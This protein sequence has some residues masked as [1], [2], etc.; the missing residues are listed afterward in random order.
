MDGG[1]VYPSAVLKIGHFTQYRRTAWQSNIP[2][3]L[4][5]WM[6]ISTRRVEN[7]TP[8]GKESAELKFRALEAQSFYMLKKTNQQTRTTQSLKNANRRGKHFEL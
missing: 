4:P 3:A 5:C 7:I 2:I 1:T 6:L 8:Q